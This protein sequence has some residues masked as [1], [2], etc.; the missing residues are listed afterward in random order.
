MNG[1][2]RDGL[3]QCKLWSFNFDRW[4][5]P[6]LLSI[7]FIDEIEVKA[8]MPIG[9][10]ENWRAIQKWVGVSMAFPPE[11]FPHPAE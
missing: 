7:K 6:Y 2:H 5:T 3:R 8:P 10:S 11:M 4:R 1:Q 9:R